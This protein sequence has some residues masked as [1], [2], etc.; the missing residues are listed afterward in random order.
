MLSEAA[1]RIVER[2][3][4]T[5]EYVFHTNGK[6]LRRDNFHHRMW[7]PARKKAELEFLQFHDLRKTNGQRIVDATGNIVLV[8]YQLG[9]SDVRTTQRAYTREP[10]DQ[11][12]EA[13]RKVGA[14]L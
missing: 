7:S 1:V 10:K 9:H 11:M 4:V 14:G 5:C 12:R 3:P 6:R 2:Q 13:L 8:Q